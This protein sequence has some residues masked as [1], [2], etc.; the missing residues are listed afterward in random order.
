MKLQCAFGFHEW[1]GCRCS[2][3]GKTRNEGHDWSKDCERCAKCSTTRSDSHAWAGCKCSNCGKTRDEGHDWS[4]DCERCASC[5]TTRSGSHAWAGCK[6]SSCG[7]SRDESHDWTKD[8][9]KCSRCGKTRR[10]AHSWTGCQCSK[11]GRTRD[12][13]HDWDG[14]KCARCGR[15]SGTYILGGKGPG[16]GIV[17]YVDNTGFHGLEAKP[18]DE[19]S[20][21]WSA[22]VSQARSYGSGWHLPTTSELSLLYK[23]REVVG[24]FTDDFYWSSDE[25]NS[26]NGDVVVFTHGKSHYLRKFANG[27]HVRAVRA[28]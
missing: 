28:F 8:C 9:E 21:N 10:E 19:G 14:D 3:C 7:K 22:A 6:C 1:K 13:G 26:N 20:M 11:C 12:E 15:I 2:R 27:C 23:Q 25:F 18:S 24:G 4:K 17:F 16:G 5:S